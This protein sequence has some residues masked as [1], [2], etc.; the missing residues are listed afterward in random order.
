MTIRWRL[1]LLYSGL[2]AI[3]LILFGLLLFSVFRWAFVNEVDSTL[4]ETAGTVAFV[5]RQRGRLPSLDSL[6]DRSTRVLVRTPSGEAV[7]SANFSGLF[8]LPRA[9]E[10]GEVVYTTEVDRDGVP[11]RLYTLP[12]MQEGHPL[13]YVQVAYE[14]TILNA[15]IRRMILLL[16]LGTAV[17]AGISAV[18]SWWVAR[19]AIAPV[20][21]VARAAQ[22]VGESADLSL[23]VP[24]PGT[25]D[26]VGVLVGT[27]NDMLDQLQGLYGRLA[28]SVDAQQRFVADASHEL[29]TPL[30]IIRGN[31]DY[32][33]KAGTLDHE[34]LLDMASEAARMTRLVDELLALA[35]ADAGQS[36]ELQ[37]VVLGPLVM[38][39]CR[40]AQAL[41][42]EATF[43]ME[44]PEALDR[45]VVLGHAEWLTRVLLVLIDNAF[46]YTPAGSVTVRAGR[47]GSGVVVQV[48]DTG[49][50]ITAEDL[51]HI[52]ERFYR[53]DRARGRGGTGLGLA[54]AHWIAGVHDGKLTAESEVGKGSTFSLWLPLHKA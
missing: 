2:I 25:D 50:G 18:G 37:P 27:F 49:M 1:T 54:I 47:Q 23:R 36:P 17:F 10:E 39:A 26:E 9:A 53:A 11:Y 43:Q 7:G 33:Q 45:V 3:A 52:F 8:P 29:R 15:V 51:P 16:G 22:A 20:E 21:A 35:R 38:D 13:V 14:L 34:A 41:P 12:V 44:L 4:E 42:H 46:K 30:T 5:Y 19:R 31:I 6:S 24:S 48:S 32:L 40:K 28:A